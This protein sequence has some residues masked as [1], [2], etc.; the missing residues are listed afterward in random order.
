MSMNHDFALAFGL[1]AIGCCGNLF[2]QDG[3][4]PLRPV[5]RLPDA[6]APRVAEPAVAAIAFEL[7]SSGFSSMQPQP[8]GGLFSLELVPANGV[9]NQ[10]KA[11]RIGLELNVG[12]ELLCADRFGVASVLADV[13]A[14]C[15]AQSPLD[16]MLSVGRS[17]GLNSSFRSGAFDFG[18]GLSWLA[19][20]RIVESRAAITHSPAML[21]VF[22]PPLVG[23][24]LSNARQFDFYGTAWLSERSWL[25]VLGSRGIA[26]LAASAGADQLLIDRTALS[27]SMGYGAFDGTLTGRKTRVSTA[28]EAW[29]DLDLGVSWR[30]PWSGRLSIG[31]DNVFSRA[32]KSE[33]SSA[34]A[35]AGLD[36]LSRTPYV[37]YQQDL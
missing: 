16:P 15:L 12:V 20:R 32:K 2:A 24:T 23:P 9:A 14:H 27:L 11:T 5:L 13:E 21:G 1:A 10:G 18:L 7:G 17:A 35:P 4:V 26:G 36:E 33:A 19:P 25:R 30:T 31:A 3:P 28:Q 8:L 29:L 37:R 22:L 34:L 6:A